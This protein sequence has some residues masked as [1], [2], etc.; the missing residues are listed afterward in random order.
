MIRLSTFQLL[1]SIPLLSSGTFVKTTRFCS[2]MM[3]TSGVGSGNKHASS[4]SEV[5]SPAGVGSQVDNSSPEIQFPRPVRDYQPPEIGSA[6][7]DMRVDR[8]ATSLVINPDDFAELEGSRPGSIA[9]SSACISPNTEVN[10]RHEGVREASVSPFP[11]MRRNNSYVQVLI[12]VIMLTI[13][14]RV[15][16]LNSAD[17]L[18]NSQRASFA[19][20]L[21]HQHMTAEN[22]EAA[23]P[24]SPPE[25]ESVFYKIVGD[26]FEMPWMPPEPELDFYHEDYEPNTLGPAFM[27]GVD[28]NSV[29]PEFEPVLAELAGRSH[30][31][32]CEIVRPS[33]NTDQP[34]PSFQSKT[35]AFTT[36]EVLHAPTDHDVAKDREHHDQVSKAYSRYQTLEYGR[37]PRFKTKVKNPLF[38]SKTPSLPG[39]FARS[40]SLHSRPQPPTANGP[41]RIP[42]DK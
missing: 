10:G 41:V 13:R 16:L 3:D 2:Q 29:R 18:Q 32:S 20:E 36:E 17:T 23:M 31:Q 33:Q 6:S 24:W 11:D 7:N 38:R 26:R 12:R 37:P 15:H 4:F 25:S 27:I 8:F 5:S 40:K 1:R 14:R 19:E 21:N 28:D 9:P 30:F 34:G 35:L 42:T 22:D 39:F